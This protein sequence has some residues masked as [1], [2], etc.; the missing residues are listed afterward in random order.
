MADGK[1]MAV[2]N[3]TR[4]TDVNA[5]PERKMLPAA[6]DSSAVAGRRN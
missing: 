6:K 2:K 5:W 3:S 4:D 1:Q